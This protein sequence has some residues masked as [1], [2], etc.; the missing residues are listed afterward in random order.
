MSKYKIL[1][2]AIG[3][4]GAA[5]LGFISLPLMA[6]FFSTEDIGRISILQIFSTFSI[7]F[8][9]LG[10]DQAY[11]REFHEHKDKDSLFKTCFL[12]GIVFCLILFFIIL[13]FNP[14]LISI[15]LYGID[16]T[17]LSFISIICFIFSYIIR[18][19]GLILRMQNKAFLY[20]IS[21]IT[22]KLFLI[23]Y[24]FFLYIF[25]IEKKFENLITGQAIALFFCVLVLLWNN[26]NTLYDIFKAKFD[27]IKFKE[28]IIFGFPLIIGGLASW[29]LNVA[30][31]LMLKTLSDLN[32]LGVYSM[33]FSIA[34]I[35]TIFVGVF[36]TIWSP[37]VFKW[38]SE[39]NIDH[40]KLKNIRE[41]SICFVYYVI[42]L[43][44]IFSWVIMLFLPS[45]YDLVPYLIT[46]CLLVPFFYTLSEITSI[47]IAISRKTILSMYSSL[48]VLC[49]NVLLNYI[50]ISHFGASG[51]ALSISLS[52]WMLLYIKTEFSK[53]V[54]IPF[55][56]RKTYYITFLLVVL[57]SINCLKLFDDYILFLMWLLFF[58]LG[59]VFFK[60]C[61]KNI[62]IIACGLINNLKRGL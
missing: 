24:I 2:Y 48:I 10:L 17:Y 19:L 42:V 29:G 60:S 61:L 16:S 3:P 45:D 32:E 53:K 43:S 20:S 31:K 12:P 27:L 33:A 8:F 11:V 39:N 21:Q 25:N 49:F 57:A 18:F 7:L 6:W 47:G 59:F 5:I 30:D 50:F 23:N 4:F 1:S 58:V 37:M 40:T 9:C 54:W 38:I 41:Y 36:N 55:D 13:V 62:F 22:P 51:A 44:G 46:S 28:I 34:G 14:K 26:R 52:F 56:V 15:N 35:A